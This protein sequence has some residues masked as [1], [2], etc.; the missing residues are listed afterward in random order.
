VG[1]INIGSVTQTGQGSTV[2]GDVT[3]NNNGSDKSWA[4]VEAMVDG[5]LLDDI[6]TLRGIAESGEDVDVP[7][8]VIERIYAASPAALELAGELVSKGALGMTGLAIKKIGQY[9]K[10]KQEQ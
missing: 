4:D 7:E 1:D 9:I 5:E 8:G 2:T 10:S 6:T 3:V